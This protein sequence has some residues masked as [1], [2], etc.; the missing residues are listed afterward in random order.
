MSSKK[1]NFYL[2]LALNL[3]KDVDGLTGSNPAVG[4]I[5]V[6]NNEIISSGL[7]GLNGRP[8]SEYN[9]I[10]SCNKKK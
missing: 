1:D 9:A 6:K 3:A 10:T 7:T 5:I 2:N 8:H 4:S